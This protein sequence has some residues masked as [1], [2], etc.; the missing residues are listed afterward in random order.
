MKQNKNMKK[1]LAF[2]S[3][4]TKMKLTQIA[5]KFGVPVQSLYQ[6]R[7]YANLFGTAFSIT[8]QAY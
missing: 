7:H 3:V 8:S 5:E 1:A 2:A 6:A 4:N